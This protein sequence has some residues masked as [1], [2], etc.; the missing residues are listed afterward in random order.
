MHAKASVGGQVIAETDNYE[1][2]EGN[3]YFPPAARLHTTPLPLAANTELKNAAWYYPQP[4]EKAT[5]IKD[6]VAFYKNK[7]KIEQD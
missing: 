6:Y 1:I 5:N 4:F 2:V 3:I 7:V